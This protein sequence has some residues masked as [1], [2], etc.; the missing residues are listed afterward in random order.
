MVLRVLGSHEEVK[1]MS[2]TYI[3]RSK[4]GTVY[5]YRLY[6]DGWVEVYKPTVK[7]CAGG[8]RTGP[9]EYRKP[10]KELKEALRE[11]HGDNLRFA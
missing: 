7:R 6:Q 10:T 8:W 5:H 11:R 1:M 3:F 4:R 9:D 2:E